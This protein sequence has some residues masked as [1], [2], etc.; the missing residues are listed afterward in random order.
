MISFF[1]TL[2]IFVMLGMIVFQTLYVLDY[3]SFI[4]QGAQSD[5]PLKETGKDKNKSRNG[6][7]NTS[8]K[9]HSKKN[10]LSPPDSNSDPDPARPTQTQAFNDS[11]SS[12]LYQPSAAIVLCLKGND[13]SLE[14]CLTGLISQDYPDFQL[15]IVIH[16]PSDP[17]NDAV[18]DF[19]STL[20]FEP[21]I[22][23]LQPFD[24]NCSLKCAAIAQAVESLDSAIEVVA[25]VDSDAIVDQHWL[26]D[27]VTPFKDATVG[28]TT[29]NRWYHPESSHWG[30]LVR[31]IWNA[32]AV[33]QMQRYH[34]AWGG[35]LAIPTRVITQC[36]LVQQW[37]TAF[38][39]DTLLT[40]TLKKHKL[41]LH[42]VPRLIIENR[43]TISLLPSFHWISRQLL[44]VRLHHNAWTMVLLHGLATGIASIVAPLLALGLLL[45]DAASD[46][47]MLV[48][49]IVV[50][51]ILNLVLLS[52]IGRSNRQSID[53]RE[54]Y[55]QS[56]P[57]RKWSLIKYLMAVLVT[58][59][60]QPFAVWQANSMERVNWRGAKY[61]VKNSR[62]VKLLRLPANDRLSAT[63]N[64]AVA[65]KRKTESTRSR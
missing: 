61:A 17:A 11:P 9:I 2:T 26:A 34:I 64:P 35:S 12:E 15:H 51:Q 8:K 52:F 63:E 20:R 1:V 18:I 55:D 56:R 7:Q 38:C 53:A 29:G 47:W 24:G 21:K 23:Y 62:N 48:T 14:E 65:R 60:L 6:K 28:A 58:Q 33:V 13:A 16:G 4:T 10:N 50:Y 32:A 49:V 45:T 5:A 40:S 31:M 3:Q 27:L 39:E 19:F 41:T 42:R 36:K 46:A 54:S 22:Q 25:L 44:T 57:P 37:R 59:V 30:A 43:E